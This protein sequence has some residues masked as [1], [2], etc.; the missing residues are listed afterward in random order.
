MVSND[1]PVRNSAA[2]K[3]NYTGQYPDLAIL[4]CQPAALLCATASK[5]D[6]Y[7]DNYLS[8]RQPIACIHIH[9]T[10]ESITDDIEKSITN[11]KIDKYIF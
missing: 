3:S 1:Q 9:S 2:P 7:I 8:I 5:K 10:N 4:E 11:P 6:L